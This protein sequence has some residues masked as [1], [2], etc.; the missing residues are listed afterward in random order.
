MASCLLFV[1]SC[2]PSV[3]E[4]RLTSQQLAWQGYQLGQELRFAQ[5]TGGP[6]RTYRITDVEDRMERQYTG[7]NLTPF[8]S[9]KIDCQHIIVSAQRMDTTMGKTTV[10]DFELSYTPVSLGLQAAVGWGNVGASREI[11]VD[12]VNKGVAF[13]S[14]QYQGARLLKMAVFGGTSYGPVLR[15]SPFAG[16]ATPANGSLQTLY[17]AKSLGVVAFVEVGRG[18]WYRLP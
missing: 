12:S 15:F 8:A 6:V 7:L 5:H 18:L 9:R 10:L 16:F 14:L 2:A 3:E 4:Y 1:A 11:P 13:D 17:Y